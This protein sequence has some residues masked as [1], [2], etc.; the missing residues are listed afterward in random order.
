M[1]ITPF[2]TVSAMLFRLHVKTIAEKAD[3]NASY[4]LDRQSRMDESVTK[5][6]DSMTILT[7]SITR[8]SVSVEKHDKEIV[9]LK[10]RTIYLERFQMENPRTRESDIR[11][12][13]RRMRLDNKEPL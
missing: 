6:S 1:A 3:R 9:D 4:I 10:H 2:F 8:L 5:M 13:E 11:E 12:V 7:T